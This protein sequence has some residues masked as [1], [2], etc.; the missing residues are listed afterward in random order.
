MVLKLL[1]MVL[2]HLCL[3][4]KTSIMIHEFRPIAFSVVVHEDQNSLKKCSDKP[5]IVC[6][7][8]NHSIQHSEDLTDM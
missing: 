7:D 2:S 6:N 1:I 3:E 5:K 8:E 4:Q